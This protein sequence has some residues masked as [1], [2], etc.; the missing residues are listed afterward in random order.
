LKL[1]GFFITLEGID[2]AG[3]TAHF[4]RLVPYLRR[5]GYRVCATREPG[6]T[7][8]GERIR[9]ILVT[10]AQPVRVRKGRRADSRGGDKKG[11]L[12]PMAELALMYAARAQ[13]VAEVIRPALERGEIVVS[14]RYNDS[15][16]AYQG[17]G[18]RLGEA[19]VREMDRV[20]CGATQPDLTLVL[21]LDP[22]VALKR[23]SHRDA[24]QNTKPG[25]F[26]AE[27]LSFEQRVRAGYQ[28]LARREPARVRLIASDRPHE[29]VEADIRQVVEERLREGESGRQLPVKS[30]QPERIVAAAEI[31]R[32][33]KGKVKVKGKSQKAKGKRQKSE[34]KRQ[35]TS[36]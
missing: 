34:A 25:R 4:R 21:D 28:A 33:K 32:G 18:R 31:V 5:R 17:H 10:A 26:E 30:A 23:A 20:V 29:E 24:R 9:S 1:R 15:S 8:V 7:E 36:G 27:G 19:V 3:K 14:D 16:L 11:I 12:D 2:G 6:G 13:H 35:E 22:R